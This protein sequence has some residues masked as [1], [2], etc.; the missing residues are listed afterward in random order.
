MPG[1]R[2][3]PTRFLEAFNNP[4]KIIVPTD[5]TTGRYSHSRSNTI[6]RTIRTIIATALVGASVGAV[7]PSL[8]DA[9]NDRINE[10]DQK[11]RILERKLEIAEETAAEQA[12]KTP[13]VKADGSG[14][15]I[16]AP[17]KSYEI[18][19]RGL[20]QEDARFWFNDDENP[21]SDTLLLRRVR[22]TIEGTVGKNGEFR[23][24]PEFAGS[25]TTILDAY[26]GY[27]FS[28]AFKVR[29]GKFKAPLGL[30]R[31]QSG[32]DI[33]F[34]ER[35]HPTSLAPNRDIGL[36]LSGDIITGGVLIYEAGIFN[37]VADGGSSVTDI[38]DDKDFVARLFATPLKNSDVDALRGLSLGI[39]GSFGQE[40]GAVGNTGLTTIRSPG[41]VSV[42]SYR[43]ST[44]EADNVVADGDRTR[45]SPQFTYYLGSLGVIG[46][47]V[48]SS[49]DVSRG[50]K[51]ESL[52]NDAW[53][54]ATTYVLTGEE[55]SFKGINPKNPF[56]LSKGTWGAFELA[57]R[58]SELTVD[59]NTFPTY[60]NPD[61]AVAGIQSWALGLNWYLTRNLRSSLTY[62]QSAF[63]GGKKGG[64]REDEEILFARFQVS[65]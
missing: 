4:T 37:G 42:F 52:D 48:L 1:N 56:D 8:A 55:N 47:Y 58:Y 16:T 21:Q 2:L 45:V 34:I 30:E 53:Q 6:M 59:D 54:L 40:E 10:L 61:R 13:T 27:K 44:N 11:T 41:Q 25:G 5:R 35:A 29:A 64:D 31:L 26:T 23:F 63:D 62:E 57:L 49:Q 12:K 65:F 51:T 28:E 14:F 20:I 36:Q 60:A 7:S 9:V 17:D 39:A 43:T 46:E 38:S 50:E 32:S 15:A 22:P 3:L 19:L 24:T 18:R 33:R